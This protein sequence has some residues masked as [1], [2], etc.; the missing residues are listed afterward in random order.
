MLE[1]RTGLDA[2]YVEGT[3]TWVMADGVGV[4]T[5]SS[6]GSCVGL[7]LYGPRHH[8]GVVAHFAGELGRDTEKSG[9][10]AMEILREAC[11]VLRG[12]WT[13]WVFGGSSLNRG[14]D[15]IT[16]TGDKLTKPLIDAVRKALH[17]NRYIPINVLRNA[18][19]QRAPETQAGKYPYH[20]AVALDV[21]TG[22]ITY[23]R[24]ANLAT[25]GGSEK[26]V[27]TKQRRKSGNF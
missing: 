16:T 6:F 3:C 11:P 1:R 12:P 26:V 10:Y 7:A 20:S 4:L 23:P 8:R 5:S 17:G 2:P 18:A 25:E 24:V 15:I 22:K 14:S 13:G 21:A 19:E 27:V 9:R